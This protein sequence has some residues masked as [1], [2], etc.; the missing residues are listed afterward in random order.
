MAGQYIV[1]GM[2]LRL[3]L[4][5]KG[6]HQPRFGYHLNLQRLRRIPGTPVV[7]APD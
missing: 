4:Q 1:S 6:P 5:G 3:M 2:G 7:V